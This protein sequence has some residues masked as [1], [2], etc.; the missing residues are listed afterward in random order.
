VCGHW[1]GEGGRGRERGGEGKDQ[2]RIDG[3]ERRGA[4]EQES[5]WKHIKCHVEKRG[6]RIHQDARRWSFLAS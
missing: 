4:C 6:Q 5:G 1:S 3:E 2:C